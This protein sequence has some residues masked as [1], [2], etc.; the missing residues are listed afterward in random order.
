VEHANDGIIIVQ[1]TILKYA[2]PRMAELDGSSVELLVGSSLKE[3]VYE[4]D[5]AKVTEMFRRRMAGEKVSSTYEAVLKRRDGSPA[6]SELNVG[7]IIYEGKPAATFKSPTLEEF[8]SVALESYIRIG[9][10]EEYVLTGQWLETLARDYGVHP[11]T[12]R[13]R[14]DEA[15]RAGY[16][17]RYTEGATPDTRFEKH[18]MSYLDIDKGVPVVKKVRLY[19]GDFIIPE[20]ASVSIR[21]LKRGDK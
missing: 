3:H 21:I 12:A 2:N 9:K 15:Y 20:R 16:L 6:Y 1:D 7:M 11:V 14:L 5:M 10:G 4:T 18:V 17:E 8:S 19:H 13:N